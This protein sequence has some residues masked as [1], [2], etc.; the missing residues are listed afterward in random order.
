MD[1]EV[2]RASIEDAEAISTVIIAA[3]RES[4]TRDYP[5]EVIVQVETSFSPANVKDLMAKRW[6]FVASFDGQLVATA[7]LHGTAVRSVF[8]SPQHQGRGVGRMLMDVIHAR[9]ASAGIKALRVPSSIT[10][11]GFYRTLG[12]EKIRDELHGEECT[13]VMEKSLSA[14][15]VT[16]PPESPPTDS[17]I[18]AT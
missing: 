16:T 7:S 1:Y 17:H 3:L 4:N 14:E 15:P 5:P 18:P 8:V 12:Y 10:A 6:V 9:A 11:E 13:I 2:R